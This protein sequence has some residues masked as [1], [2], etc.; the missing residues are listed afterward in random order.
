MWADS[1]CIIIYISES[2]PV[3]KALK[4]RTG[5]SQVKVD[6]YYYG[7][8]LRVERIKLTRLI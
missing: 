4:G 1:I 7:N 6:I 8:K 3:N 5:A 2:R